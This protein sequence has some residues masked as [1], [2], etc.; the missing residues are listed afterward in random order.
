MDPIS[1]DLVA[2][3]KSLV[4]EGE[5]ELVHFTKGQRKD[6][7]AKSYNDSD[8]GPFFPSPPPIAGPAT[9]TT[10]LCSRPSSP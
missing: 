3:I 2:A 10:S 1:K 5:L 8:F 9:A 7:V 6:D 4:A